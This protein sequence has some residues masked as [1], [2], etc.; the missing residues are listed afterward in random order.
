MTF[1]IQITR[2]KFLTFLRVLQ[3]VTSAIALRHSEKIV[4]FHVNA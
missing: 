1:L 3:Y 2:I 4:I